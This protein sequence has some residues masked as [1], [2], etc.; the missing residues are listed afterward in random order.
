MRQVPAQQPQ[1]H[2]QI[3]AIQQMRREQISAANRLTQDARNRVNFLAGIGRTTV[4]VPVGEATFSLRSLKSTESHAAIR[5]ASVFVDGSPDWYFTL[6]DM[7]LA[8]SIYAIDGVDIDMVV[9]DLSPETIHELV[10]DEMDDL[11]A[12][13]LY[14]E[15]LKMQREQKIKFGLVTPEQMKEVTED[16]KKS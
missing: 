1:S 2:S 3:D 11:V 6:R 7:T 8:R 5:A 10:I 16:I 12:D 14:A 4:D 9:G 15:F 13:K